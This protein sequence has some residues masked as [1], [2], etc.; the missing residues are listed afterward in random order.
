MLHQD[1]SKWTLDYPP[2]FAYMEYVFSY[3]A[4]LIEP[5]MLNVQL[6]IV[7]NVDFI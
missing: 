2:M 4:K 6:F 5:N 3:F 7:Y 1:Y